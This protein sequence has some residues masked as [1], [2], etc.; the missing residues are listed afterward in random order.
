MDCR[1]SPR[2]AYWLSSF[3]PEMEAVAKEVA[4]LRATFP[5]SFLW[6]VTAH[7]SLLLSRTRGFAFH[8]RLHLLFRALTGVL[9]RRYDINHVFGGLGDWHHL[10]AVSKGPTVLTVALDAE[11]VATELLQKVDRFVVE[12]PGGD[13]RLRE[14]GIDG[15]KVELIYP[16]VDLRRFTPQPE[17][18]GKFTVLFA[19]SPDRA[20]WIETRGVDIVIGA[21]QR[22]PEM[23]FVLCWRPWGDALPRAQEMV[24]EAGVDNVEVSVGRVAD[25]AA[26]Y[27]EAHVTVL[28][29]RETV[30]SKPLPN[31]LVESCA[32]GRPVVTTRVCGLAPLLTETDAGTVIEPDADQLAEA[33]DS[34][35]DGWVDYA[36][37][38]RRL[39]E[40][41]FDEAKFIDGYRRVYD[42]VL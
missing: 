9:Q 28:V 11:P 5:G 16:P 25:M 24:R 14:L 31:S 23:R 27:R 34:L 36:A 21:A 39:A 1:L 12:W 15:D 6:G 35:R 30:R 19:S 17:P 20:S 40:T 10:R 22:R 29:A 42:A 8:P 13:R 41:M 26:V 7:R 4:T 32:S 18:D 37:R 3:E 38:A 33:L 2:I